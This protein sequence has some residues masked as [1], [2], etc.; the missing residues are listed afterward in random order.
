MNNTRLVFYI[1]GGIGLIS[2]ILIIATFNPLFDFILA[3]VGKCN[4]KVKLHLTQVLTASFQ[5][6]T[7][8][9]LDKD[10]SRNGRLT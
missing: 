9:R 8:L 4:K 10:T 2:G 5:A 7:R 6:K 3:K 1:L